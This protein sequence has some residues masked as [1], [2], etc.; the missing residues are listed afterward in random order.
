MSDQVKANFMLTLQAIFLSII[1]LIP[2]QEN[3]SQTMRNTSLVIFDIG[4]VL[5]AVAIYNLRK[6]LAISPIPVKKGELQAGG[7]YRFVRH[8]MYVAVIVLSAGSVLAGEVSWVRY[9]ALI[10]LLILLDRKAYFEESLLRK[11]YPSYAKY[12]KKTGKFFPKL[13]R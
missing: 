5:L 3:P 9:S 13:F 1:F 12:Q 6:S 7:L 2:N 4:I 8:P 10:G 11:K